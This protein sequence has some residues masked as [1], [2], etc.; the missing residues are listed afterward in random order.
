[1]ASLS[2]K[3]GHKIQET[4]SI[5]HLCIVFANADSGEGHRAWKGVRADRNDLELQKNGNDLIKNVA[6]SCGGPTIAVIHSVGPVIL[7]DFANLPQVK[8]ILYANLPGQESGNALSDVIFGR[9]DASGR[10]PYTIG[11][12][13]KDYGPDALVQYYPNH[14]IPQADFKEGLYVDYRHFDKFAVEPEY[15]FGFG[16]SYTTFEYSDLQIRGL[17]PKSRLPDPRPGGLSA[18]SYDPSI[19]DPSSALYPK[20]LR[21]LTKYIYPYITSID[22]VRRAPYP[23]PDGYDTVQEPSQ[24]GGGE[25][26]NPSLFEPYVQVDARI[27]NVGARTGKEVVQVYVSLSPDAKEQSSG[28]LIDTPVRVLRNFTKIEL[29]PNDSQ[30]VTLT[31]TRKDLSYWSV[32]EQNWIMPDGDFTIAVGRSSRDLLLQGTY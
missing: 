6:S 19:P 18:P 32:L 7:S 1:M 27:T 21:K 2:N 17:K 8:A 3:L 26:G 4:L 14:L 15:P 10:L 9:V 25:G 16:L 31:L 29:E 24:A 12:S 23:Y 11:K 28:D 22:Q 13:L 30:V 5:Q 20:G